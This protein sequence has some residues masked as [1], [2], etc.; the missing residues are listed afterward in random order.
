MPCLSGM[1]SGTTT[2][3]STMTAITIDRLIALAAAVHAVRG[4]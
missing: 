4:A 3:V 2:G 1:G